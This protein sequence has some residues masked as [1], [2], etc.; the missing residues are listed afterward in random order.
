MSLLKFG[1]PQLLDRIPSQTLPFLV[2]LLFAWLDVAAAI[3]CSTPVDNFIGN[4]ESKLQIN[5]WI[6]RGIC[7]RSAD[8]Y[9]VCYQTL[10]DTLENLN[11][12]RSAE[13]NGAAGVLA[14]LPT[15]GAL[16]GAPTTEIWRLL[17]VVP[18]GGVIAMT[19]SFGG[20]IL[21]VRVE[22][23]ENDLSS[24]R[25]TLGSIVSLRARRGRAKADVEDEARIKL[26]QLVEKI[27]AR[28]H[29]DESQ[30]L[31]KAQLS[32]GL[33]GMILLFL[34]AQAA[35]VIVEQGGILP[36]WCSS[37]WW[38][39]LWYFLVTLT[40]I[41]DNWAQIPF[42]ETWKVFV[43]DVPY[44]M[45]VRGGDK[46]VSKL[47]KPHSSVK[48]VLQQLASLKA[49]S[50]YF[51]GSQQYT[52]PRNAVL[53]MVSVINDGKERVG[54]LLRLFTKCNSIAT[55]VVGTALFASVQL[56]ALP[57]AV[58]TLTL[59]LAAG[60]FSRAITGWIVSGAQHVIA[61][62]LSLDEASGVRVNGDEYRKIQVE[63]GGHVFVEQR[64]VA[65]RT[66]WHVRL[67]GVLSEPF[68][69]RKI[70]MSEV[71][72]KDYK[73]SEGSSQPGDLEYGLL[74]K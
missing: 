66:P 71:V 23:Y 29:Q 35:M 17:T 61:R 32:F 53:V 42:K 67:L 40:A 1:R 20:A 56:L 24:D 48:H 43:S 39:H 27:E 63:I 57:V 51:S 13:Y 72:R 18:F 60:V 31:P 21:P 8:E 55:F 68:D 58:M 19:L 59:V 36:W 14:L 49:G 62:I 69:L 6:N 64:R 16:L 44:D 22:D 54:P 70:D 50:A 3:D 7:V 2:T 52:K 41:T 73:E 11:N 5:Q 45:T 28:M 4:A 10:E 38:M 30:R 34:G 12:L 15:I 25:Q 26:D 65:Y 33:L 74:R 37:R 46:I 47:E 9:R